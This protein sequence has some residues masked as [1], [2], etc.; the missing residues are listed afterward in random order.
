MEVSDVQDWNALDPIDVTE[1]G[2]VIEVS[3]KQNW[4]TVS[5]IVV[6]EDGIVMEVSDVHV[7]SKLFE[8]V[9]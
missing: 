9:V 7:E 2:I 8:S 6:I 5:P 1:F 4:K 3:D